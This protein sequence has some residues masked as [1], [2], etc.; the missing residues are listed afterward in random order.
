[1]QVI[2]TK[3]AVRQLAAILAH[4]AAENPTAAK[5]FADRIG[6]IKHFLSA[7]PNSGFMLPHGRLRRF[8]VH[9]YPYLIYFETSAHAVRIVRIRHA[10]RYRR[11]FHEPA[12]AFRY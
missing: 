12:R 2:L 11:A 3:P 9:P 10:A 6:E 8:P 5:R 7:N 1:M 4:I